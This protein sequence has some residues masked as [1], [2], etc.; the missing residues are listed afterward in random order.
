ME[1]EYFKK[2]RTVHF[3]LVI[4]M[5]VIF[6]PLCMECSSKDQKPKINN[7]ELKDFEIPMYGYAENV[8]PY[9]LEDGLIRGVTYTVKMPYPAPDV[10]SFYDEAMR[11]IGYEPFVEEHLKYADRKWQTFVDS[12][13][14]RRPYIA[15][16]TASWADGK[17]ETR[18]TLIL[19]Y[20]WHVDHNKPKIILGE[21]FDL[22]ITFQIMPFFNVPR[23]DE[24]TTK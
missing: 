15:Q 18:T 19:Q 17:R 2:M 5:V 20:Y 3:V 22:N 12:T 23:G 14:K 1:K 10:L 13:K 16:L 9:T 7:L 11:K 21:N 6:F 8:K 24:F 4:L